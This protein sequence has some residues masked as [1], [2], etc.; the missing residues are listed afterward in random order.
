MTTYLVT[1][2]SSGLGLQVALRLAEAGARHLILP[3]RSDAAAEAIRQA[4]SA[5]PTSRVSTPFMDLASLASVAAFLQSFAR[6]PAPDLRGL[7]LNAG[8][9]SAAA[10]EFTVDG[11]ETSFAVNHLAHWLLLQGLLGHLAQGA[12]VGWTASGVHDPAETSARLFG[13]RGGRYTVGGAARARR[14]RARRLGGAS[15][16]GCL[17]H[18][19]AL[20]RDRRARPRRPLTRS[21]HVLFLRSRPG[22]GHRH[23][24]PAMGR[25]R[26]GS[27]T[28]CCLGWPACCPGRARRSRLRSCSPACSPAR[29]RWRPT[30]PTSATAASRANPPHKPAILTS[31]KP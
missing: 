14:G 23:R 9:Q 2:A 11:H 12:R 7:L 19:E 20:Q 17:C 25:R 29:C 18:L 4:L 5:A 31:P 6:E 26:A 1:G 24:A 10:L 30:V 3:V 27:G 21:G 13:F 22:A 8:V 28:S 15:L 16:S